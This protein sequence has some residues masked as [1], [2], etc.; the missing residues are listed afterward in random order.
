[1]V[2]QVDETCALFAHET[3]D[4]PEM[5]LPAC[6]PRKAT[7]GSVDSDTLFQ[8]SMESYG[9][10]QRKAM[11]YSIDRD[12]FA[13]V[14]TELSRKVR[15]EVVSWLVDTGH[16]IALNSQT[17]A[18][19]VNCFDRFLVQRRIPEQHVGDVAAASLLIAA[20]VHDG[21]PPP[22][23]YL[24]SYTDSK[25]ED[26]VIMEALMLDK[27]HWQVNSVTSNEFVPFMI[28]RLVRLGFSASDKLV[29]M[30]L[31]ISLLEFGFATMS[32]CLVAAA[33]VLLASELQNPDEDSTCCAEAFA[34]VLDLDCADL[35]EARDLLYTSF[36]SFFAMSRSP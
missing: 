21:T 4:A 32:T 18:I 30:L 17:I 10:L 22:L 12:Y 8:L 16:A 9:H 33:C 20:K 26:I 7:L 6:T 29:E 13:D 15:E 5:L 34:D 27:L 11:L 24:A 31:D 2:S 35:L 23:S 14:Q 1:M 3:L 36:Q 28:H 25:P 19:A